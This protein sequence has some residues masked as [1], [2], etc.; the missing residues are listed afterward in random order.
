MRHHGLL[1]RRRRS[2]ARVPR[3][4]GDG[5]RREGLPRRAAPRASTCPSWRP[6][7]SRGSPAGG[8]SSG[9]RCPRRHE[10]HLIGLDLGTS[11]LKAVLA[12]PE[13]G[14]VAV[15]EHGLSDAP[16]RCRAGRRTTRRTGA[17]RRRARRAG[18]ARARGD[19]AATEVAAVCIVGQRDIV[20]LIDADGAP[21]RPL[22]PLVGPAR[23]ARDR[24]AVRPHGP[25]PPALAVS[26]TGPIPGLVLPNL[27]WT[28]AHAPGRL[29]PRPRGARRPRTTSRTG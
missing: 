18:A 26:G 15:A 3:R 5:G 1:G 28:A 12:H 24:G 4:V 21:A 9:R 22:H 29:R 20:A 19:V 2:R 14:V 7:T 6:T 16:A 13:H 17:A 11:A 27:V 10:S 8:T 25:R 23:P